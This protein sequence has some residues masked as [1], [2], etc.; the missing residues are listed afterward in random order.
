MGENWTATHLWESVALSVLG[1]VKWEQL[2]N[3]K[4]SWRSPEV[5]RVWELFGEI[6]K[7]TNT[8][9][10]SLSWQQATDMVVKGEAAFNIMG[11]W[12][13]GYM[14]TTLKLKP[15]TGFG[16]AASPGHQGHIHDAL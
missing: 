3:G 14:T 8:D 1:P 9:A 6:L 16:W 12:A 15:G 10:P 4:L 7:Y 11:D 2:W 5:I 13:S